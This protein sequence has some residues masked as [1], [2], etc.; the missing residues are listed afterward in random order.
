MWIKHLRLFLLGCGGRR[1]GFVRFSDTVFTSIAAMF[2]SCG[3][4]CA[5]VDGGSGRCGLREPA[6]GS[7]GTACAKGCRSRS[8]GSCLSVAID[9]AACAT[10]LAVGSRDPWQQARDGGCRRDARDARRACCPCRD[11][12]RRSA[13][14]FGTAG[15][16]EGWGGY[17]TVF[18]S[19]AG[20]VIVR[21]R[22][23]VGVRS[24]AGDPGLE[25]GEAGIFDG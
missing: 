2:G 16:R 9:A 19:P 8:G 18:V 12:H 3:V 17:A 5:R 10:M 11:A 22:R 25:Q 23:D 21:A 24:W 14:R 13:P 4:P 6:T 15:R 1:A 20:R 7:S